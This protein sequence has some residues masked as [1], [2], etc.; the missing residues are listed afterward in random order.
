MEMS[1]AENPNIA[2]SGINEP[3]LF[4]FAAAAVDHAL[5]VIFVVD[6]DPAMLESV[7]APLR[8]HGYGVQ[9]FSSPAPFLT[10]KPHYGP[11]CAILDMKNRE[12]NG[13]AVQSALAASGEDMPVIFLS[14]EPDTAGT[15]LA[16]KQGAA[17]FL[18]KPVLPDV[19]I[20]SVENTI[21][22]HR[23]K[24][25]RMI[26]RR[27]AIFRFARLTTREREVAQLVGEGLPNKVIAAHLGTAEKTVKHH[28]ARAM[29]K[30][31]V[32]SVPQLV[33]LLDG[34]SERSYS[35]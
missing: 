6:D 26:G 22:D 30:L 24:L 23:K 14:G 8:S 32:D 19:L 11:A 7:S 15:V 1:A 2:T 35:R 21:S 4:Q 17:D 10:R 16:M 25:K 31:G 12:M 9:T 33:R 13:M 18:A 27:D 5:P 20:R 34:I 28:R 29:M 3:L